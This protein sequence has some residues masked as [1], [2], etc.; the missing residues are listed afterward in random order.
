M[1]PS[2]FTLLQ[3]LPLTPN[4]KVDLGALPVPDSVRPALDVSYAVPRN[5]L[6]HAIAR[7]W[8]EVL[9]VEKVGIDDNIFDLGGHS[10]HLAQVHTRLH[11]SLVHL[12][13]L[14]MFRYPTINALAAYLSRGDGG[15]DS[16]SFQ[17]ARD[18]ARNKQEALDRR[19]QL[20]TAIKGS[21]RLI[22]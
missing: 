19:R 12:T 10:L 5:A 13:L 18:L 15:N 7:V 22:P 14:D 16:P 6:E 3:R 17:Q 4:G 9:Q 21:G 2:T 20:M 8:Q 1:V 11:E